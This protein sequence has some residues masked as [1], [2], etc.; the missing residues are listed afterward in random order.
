MLHNV[1][2]FFYGF[3]DS[4]KDDDDDDDGSWYES[5]FLTFIVGFFFTHPGEE[6]K[7]FMK[8]KMEFLS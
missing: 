5:I 6:V 2:T 3:Q 8:I 4:T 7:Y 1:G